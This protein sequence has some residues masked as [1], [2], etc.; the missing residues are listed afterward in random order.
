MSGTNTYYTGNLTQANLI[1]KELLPA[2]ESLLLNVNK[3]FFTVKETMR[4]LSI[5]RTQLYYLQKQN[6]LKSKR[7]GRKV[8]I[9]KVAIHDL[10][11][12]GHND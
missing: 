4:I 1:L 5:S 12:N 10:V 8:Y 7:V 11:M 2:I 9:T 3:D 6:V